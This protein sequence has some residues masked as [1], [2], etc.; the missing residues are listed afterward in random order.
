V[1]EEKRRELWGYDVLCGTD[2]EPVRLT[3]RA[4]AS[5]DPPMFVRDFVS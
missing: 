2:V 3:L 1:K 5:Y 4:P